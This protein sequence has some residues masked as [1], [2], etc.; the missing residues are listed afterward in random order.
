MPGQS[1]RTL[2]I[3]SNS[4]A[5]LAAIEFHN[6]LRI[7]AGKIGDIPGNRNLAAEVPPFRLEKAQLL[8]EQTLGLRGVVAK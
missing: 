3:I 7:V 4:L 8:P 5:M 2:L 1:R 6:H